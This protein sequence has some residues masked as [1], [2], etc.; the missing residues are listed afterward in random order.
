M[1]NPKAKHHF[2]TKLEFRDN[3]E[4]EIHYTVQFNSPSSHG[5]IDDRIVYYLN[6]EEFLPSNTE[7]P[8]ID[9]LCDEH[10]ASLQ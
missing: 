5:R 6:G 3:L 9:Q 4:V 7:W 2:R 1:K 10:W 8:L